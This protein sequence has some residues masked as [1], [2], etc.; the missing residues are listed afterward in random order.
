MSLD[1]HIARWR[2]NACRPPGFGLI[3][4]VWPGLRVGVVIGPQHV[5]FPGRTRIRFPVIQG[6][7][8][9]FLGDS[10]HGVSDP[11]LAWARG[12][13]TVSFGLSTGMCQGRREVTSRGPGAAALLGRLSLPLDH[14]RSRLTPAA[15]GAGLPSLP[16]VPALR[17]GVRVSP[18]TGGTGVPSV[19]PV[20]PV[21]ASV[22]GAET[23]HRPLQVWI[24]P[25][26]AGFGRNEVRGTARTRLVCPRTPESPVS[27]PR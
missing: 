27:F 16:S 14:V 3:Q 21:S 5:V 18:R 24:Q 26:G 10:G 1:S 22:S 25:V 13:L 4:G 17:S 15:S 20:D 11:A 2:N 23:H 7:H 12:M 19:V 9:P 8:G 6:S